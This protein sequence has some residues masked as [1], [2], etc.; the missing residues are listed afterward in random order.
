MLIQSRL[1]LK[2]VHV[3]FSLKKKMKMFCLRFCSP[4]FLESLKIQVFMLILSRLLLKIVLVIFP[5]K[6]QTK[7]FLFLIPLSTKFYLHQKNSMKKNDTNRYKEQTS[8]H[9]QDFSI[10]DN[11][12]KSALPLNIKKKCFT[13]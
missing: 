12:E 1:L 4:F 6:T 11:V 8:D 5:F 9:A 2:I 3:M 10:S 7:K 13:F